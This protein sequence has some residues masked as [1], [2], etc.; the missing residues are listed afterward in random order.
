[1]S[2]KDYYEV[3]NIEKNASA[4]DI[5]NAYRKLA[6]KYHPDI[7]KESNAE[8]KFKEI[9]E[10]YEV[11][12]DENKRSQYDRYGHN[13]SQG[14]G[15]F[16]SQGF[17]GF[18]FS[19][20]FNG[21]GSFGGFGGNQRQS[22]NNGPIKGDN[23]SSRI[24]ISFIDSVLGVELEQNMTKHET[25]NNCHGSG[26][27]NESD[28]S[29]CNSC[30][31]SGV[32]VV[33]RSMMG[34]KIQMQQ[35]CHSCHGSGQ[36]VLN[37]CKTCHG[38]GSVEKSSKTKIKIPA[39]VKDGQSMVLRGFGGPG[40]KGAPSG[41]LILEI[42]VQKHKYYQLINDTIHLELLV[43]FVDI[44]AE[45]TILAPTPYGN[46]KIKMKDDYESGTIVKVKDKG[47]P[48]LNSNR[49]GDIKFHLNVYVPKMKTKTKKEI[50]ELTHDLDDKVAEKHIKNINENK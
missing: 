41:D 2:K 31:G 3:L 9:N 18:D 47:M 44:L 19:D 23:Y 29:Q 33:V 35:E 21:F 14:F 36:M 37:K 1:M 34:Q 30:H 7:N 5:K 48:I 27:Q 13:A 49:K 42:N 16:E 26:A 25:C 39:G 22:R 8:E 28:V 20:L 38:K 11:L 12:G 24:N 46:I 10:A 4:S 6:R 45:N 50:L 40:T 17:G 15:G 43:S 32:E